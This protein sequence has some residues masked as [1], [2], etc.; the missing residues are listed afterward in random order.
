[1]SLE[2]VI[3]VKPLKSEN[4]VVYAF[5]FCINS[6]KI[7]NFVNLGMVNE[8]IIEFS[9]VYTLKEIIYFVNWETMHD[10]VLLSFVPSMHKLF[11]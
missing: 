9:I 1:M 8:S 11:V 10:P 2:N 5:F 7:V 3:Y 4:L 6:N